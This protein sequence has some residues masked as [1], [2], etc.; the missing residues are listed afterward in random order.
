MSALIIVI[1]TITLMVFANALY[2]GAEFATVS[3]RKTR[4]NQMASE[5]NHLAKTLLPI[6]EDRKAL[7]NYVAACQ[8]GI[9]VSSLVLGAYGQNTVAVMLAPLLTSL[10]NM[11][12]AAAFSISATAVLIFLTILQV[13]MGEL[14]PKSIAI[15]Y[16]EKTALMT[17]IPM[18]WSLVIF[19][20]VLYAP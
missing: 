15:Q 20:Y 16:P 2:V 14:F 4:I 10:G 17:V 19:R 13:V 12:E 1:I 9:T 6:V 11:A 5:G 18:K 7:D 3:S 8:V